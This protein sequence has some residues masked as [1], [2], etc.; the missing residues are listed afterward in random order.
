MQAGVTRLERLQTR[1]QKMHLAL[2]FLW[3]AREAAVTKQRDTVA[4]D[5][6]QASKVLAAQEELHP[7]DL[8]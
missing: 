7:R 3:Q 5:G 8:G 2:Q 1:M 6:L 4:K